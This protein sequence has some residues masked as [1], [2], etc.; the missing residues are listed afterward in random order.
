[1]LSVC[2]QVT[3]EI[4]AIERLEEKWMSLDS[5]V[6]EWRAI[7]RPLRQEQ[8]EQVVC[9]RLET[10]LFDRILQEPESQRLLIPCP[11]SRQDPHPFRLLREHPT[12]LP[13]QEHLQGDSERV[14]VAG[15][16]KG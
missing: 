13:Q 3:S 7:Q 12:I 11:I 15:P 2:A 8:Q 16:L 1:M 4:L 6:C 9:L 14:P 10:A 5:R